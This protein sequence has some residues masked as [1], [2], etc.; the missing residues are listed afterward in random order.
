VDPGDFPSSPILITCNAVSQNWESTSVGLVSSSIGQSVTWFGQLQ[1]SVPVLVS[2]KTTKLEAGLILTLQISLQTP[3]ST[4][5]AHPR[6]TQGVLTLQNP[7]SAAHSL[8]HTSLILPTMLKI[9][10]KFSSIP[11]SLFNVMP[12]CKVLYLNCL[13][14]T[15]KITIII[16]I[17]HLINYLIK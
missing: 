3:D 14:R 13:M 12:N 11:A 6:L 9:W 8:V 4:R 10:M 16:I 17:S 1:R 5:P 15:V 2:K 7:P